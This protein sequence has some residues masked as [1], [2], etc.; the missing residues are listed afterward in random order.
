MPERAIC[1]YC[2]MEGHRAHACPS[3]KVSVCRGPN[4]SCLTVP[5]RRLTLAG[6]FSPPGLRA[7][8][9]SHHG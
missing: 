1:T 7:I 2:G 9:T 5:A 4:R 6:F 3:R 8:G